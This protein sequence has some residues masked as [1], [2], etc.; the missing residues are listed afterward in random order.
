MILIAGATGLLGGEICRLLTV[1]GKAVRALVRSTSDQAKVDML[2]GYGVELTI[3]D[4]RDR[5]TLDSACKG[6]SAV[7]STVSALPYSYEPEENNIQTVDLNGNK[8]LIDAAKARGVEHFVFI[9]FTMQNDF[10]LKNAKREVE[11]YL[12]E[13][14]LTYT[15]LRPSYFMEFW[16]S[17]AVGFDGANAKAQIYGSG[18]NPISWIS[19]RDV[20]KFVLVSLEHPAAQNTTLKLGGPE[21]ISQLD[22]VQIFEGL[23]GKQFELSFVPEDT[24]RDQQESAADP[25][26]QSF[27]GLMRWYARGDVID[28]R[29]MLEKFPVQLTSL[30]DY[31]E[32]MFITA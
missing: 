4:L 2:K 30:Q 22:A 15:I 8:N 24:L 14:G 28:I 6:V 26:Q 19:Y 32:S 31:I 16:F 13:S 25:A 9:S 23:G 27:A 11:Q 29:E 12:K 17:Q 18:E 21:A 10:P 7:V 1:D 3:G 20:A 5:S